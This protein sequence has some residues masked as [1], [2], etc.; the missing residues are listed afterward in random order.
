MEMYAIMGDG[1]IIDGEFLKNNVGSEEYLK[2]IPSY[3]K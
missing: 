3:I 1:N 2:N